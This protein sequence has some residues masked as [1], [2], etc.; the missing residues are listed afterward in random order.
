M[1]RGGARLVRTAQQLADVIEVWLKDKEARRTTGSIGKQLIA[2][3]LGAVDRTLV[4]LR[5]YV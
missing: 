2:E 5:E 3:N 4:H 1:D